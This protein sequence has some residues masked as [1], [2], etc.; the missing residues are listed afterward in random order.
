MLTSNDDIL[1]GQLLEI[2]QQMNA[3]NELEPLLEYAL[4]ISIEL[5][6]ALYGFVVLVDESGELAFPVARDNKGNNVIEPQDQVSRT[7]IYRVMQKKHYILTTS[8]VDDMH[9]ENA[10]SVN[11]LNLNSV[12]CVPLI[13]MGIV[14]GVIYL[15]NRIIKHLFD[16]KHA[17][18]LTYLAGHAAVCIHNMML[19]EKLNAAQGNLIQDL[20]DSDDYAKEAAEA[21]NRAMEEERTR[22]LYGFIQDTSH[23]FRTPLTNIKTSVHLLSRKIDMEVAGNYLDRI[24]V[25]VEMIV[26]LVDALNLLAKLDME[27]DY[28]FKEENLSYVFRTIW[29]I[30]S[31]QA[32]K[33]D[34]KV[35]FHLP[36]QPVLVNLIPDYA[37]QA[38]SKILNNAIDFTPAN[39]TISITISESNDMVYFIVD[40]TGIGISPQ[41]LSEITKRFYQVDQSGNLRGLGLG[42]SITERIMKL[43]D[44]LLEIESE[45]GQGTRVTLGF[46]KKSRL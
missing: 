33:K 4:D 14:I 19:A 36:E 46:S 3:T 13:S 26:N 6:N 25:Q 21:I 22:L 44:G 38:I 43:H 2:A 37:R 17:E 9:F 28:V 18:P 29:E 24:S 16:V 45:L 23:Q 30:K 20:S 1:L 39:Q 35:T 11:M 27:R 8:A 12:L 41:D 40:D 7:I 10:E 32:R 31:S 15:E 5:L 34:I 42:L